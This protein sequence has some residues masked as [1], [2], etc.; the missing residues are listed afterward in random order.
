MAAFAGGANLD[1]AAGA[2]LAG[3]Y[4]GRGEDEAEPPLPASMPDGTGRASKPVMLLLE[5]ALLLAAPP[6]APLLLR[7]ASRAARM[8]LTDLQ[9]RAQSSFQL[10]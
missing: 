9:M 1:V 3:S 4:A 2:I 5:E 8:S 7:P 6:P 10:I